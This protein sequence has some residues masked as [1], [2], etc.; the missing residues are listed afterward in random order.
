MDSYGIDIILKKIREN[1]KNQVIKNFL[2]DIV[3]EE[4][5]NPWK[6]KNLYKV[7]LRKNLKKLNEDEN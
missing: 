5:D 3:N 2:I 6:W 1:C 7:K 4:L